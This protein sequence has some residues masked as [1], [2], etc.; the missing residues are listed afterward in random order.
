MQEVRVGRE[1]AESVSVRIRIIPEF[2]SALAY[3]G[4]LLQLRVD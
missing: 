2:P 1:G 4:L 3:R